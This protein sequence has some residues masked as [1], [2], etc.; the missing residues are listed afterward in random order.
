MAKPRNF[1]S[2]TCYDL[3]EVRD[4]LYQHLTSLG[5]E[6][7]ASDDPKFGVT[8]GA[9]S[10]HACLDEVD[11]AD[12]LILVVG[13]RRGGTFVGSEKSITNEEYRRAAQRR[14][15]ILT[16]I[17]KDVMRA[18][19]MF[20]KNP[21]ADVS[22][23]VDDVRIFD[24]IDL[25]QSAS[26]SNWI[27]QF[28]KG[29][30]ICEVLTAQFAHIVKMFSENM[31]AEKTPSKKSE[32]KPGRAASFPGRLTQLPA[33]YQD[34]DKAEAWVTAGLKTVHKSISSILK[35]SAQGKDEKLKTLWL[36]GR[37]GE[38][39]G[40]LTMAN[41]QFKQFAWSTHKGRRVFI[42]LKTFG[43]N[44]YYSFDDGHE[45][46]PPTETIHLE[47]EEDEGGEAAIALQLYV[48]TL[49]ERFGEDAGLA[50]F[51][52]GDLNVFS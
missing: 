11:R 52:R 6:A 48:R 28:E 33:D 10:H 9:H 29:S 26:E 25:I 36:F 49:V 20:K 41:D 2:S 14:I 46:E 15:P 4:R 12:Y 16:F 30:E 32:A 1:I 31:V 51:K 5:M 21:G 27:W 43:V 38:G 19:R 42:Q 45:D 13:G 50:I 47:F 22:D 34:D 40:T 37:Y 18:R 39:E 44:G 35:S 3:S 8:P 17:H 7:V 24:F 23:F